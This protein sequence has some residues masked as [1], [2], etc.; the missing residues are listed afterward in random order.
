MI[1]QN[2]FMDEKRFKM[3]EEFFD[4]QTF[5]DTKTKNIYVVT[6]EF[7]QKGSTIIQEIT[8]ESSEY[9]PNLEVY[10]EWKRDKSWKQND[11]DVYYVSTKTGWVYM[12]YKL[13]GYNPDRPNTDMIVC[14]LEY[15]DENMQDGMEVQ[16][17][18][19]WLYSLNYE[20]PKE[21]FEDIIE[22]YEERKTK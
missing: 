1:H 8:S 5:Y 9:L 12:F 11:G 3:F 22:E 20:I 10:K 19:G 2:W 13:K 18:V 17:I 6:D 21:D 14:M 15:L 4:T 7:G 16:E